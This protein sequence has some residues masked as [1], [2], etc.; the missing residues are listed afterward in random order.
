MPLT[1]PNHKNY[2][3][4][5][6]V[7]NKEIKRR[8]ETTILL[9][10]AR[11]SRELGL[12]IATQ[13]N[14]AR[15]FTSDRDTPMLLTPDL[16]TGFLPLHLARFIIDANESIETTSAQ[17]NCRG[18]GHESNTHPHAFGPLGLF[19]L[20]W[21]FFQSPG[22]SLQPQRYRHAFRMTLF[23]QRG[24]YDLKRNH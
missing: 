2:F 6:E 18:T 11:L 14:M 17:I 10:F 7:R 8:L 16:P 5:V 20:N 15:F 3:A 12:I 22:R 19:I 21:N 1:Q 4:R 24:K 23:L 13:I 9:D